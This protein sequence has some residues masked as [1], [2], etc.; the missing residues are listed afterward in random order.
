MDIALSKK[1]CVT[2]GD[3]WEPHCTVSDMKYLTLPQLDSSGLPK[4]VP[5]IHHQGGQFHE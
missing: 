5:S 2:W 4:L 3:L 1:W